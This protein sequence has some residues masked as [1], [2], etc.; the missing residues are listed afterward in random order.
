[1]TAVRDA[2]GAPPMKRVKMA[3][4][5]RRASAGMTDI[6][7]L[8][9]VYSAWQRGDF[10]PRA[11]AYDHDMEWGWS[12]EFPGLAGVVRDSGPRSGRML[13]WL[14]SWEHWRV[15]PEGY[16]AAGE[17]ILVLTRYLGCG[18]AS[19]VEVDAPGAHLWRMRNGKAVR[20]EIFSSRERAL[21]AAGL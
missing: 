19:G 12:A 4:S 3:R 16:I 13:R 10:R 1:M 17:S 14:S 7:P 15:E 8:R 18:K 5:A 2:F 20:L 21:D 6:E 11:D 9:T